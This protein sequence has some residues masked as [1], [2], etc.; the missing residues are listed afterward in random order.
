MWRP[1][2][3]PNCLFFT[4]DD[5]QNT[6]QCEY[7]HSSNISNATHFL[8]LHLLPMI[9]PPVSTVQYSTVQYTLLQYFTRWY[10]VTAASNNFGQWSP[11]E[12]MMKMMRE[13]F[14]FYSP[15][16]LLYLYISMGSPL[17]EHHICNTVP[18]LYVCLVYSSLASSAQSMSLNLTSWMAHFP[19]YCQCYGYQNWLLWSRWW[20]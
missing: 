3:S 20:M 9:T 16:S 5:N 11:C 10:R 2:H 8:S 6:I 19:V 7:S 1:A 17:W 14:V 13:Y 15:V 12:E 18:L 4:A